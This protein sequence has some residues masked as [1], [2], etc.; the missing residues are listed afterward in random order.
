M[1]KRAA[2]I[3]LFMG[4][5]SFIQRRIR[6]SMQREEPPVMTTGLERIAVKARCEPK[7]RFTSLAHHITKDRVW[8]SLSQIPAK[9]AAGVD[10]PTVT[11]AKE[12]FEE[13][14]ASMLQSVRRQGYRAPEIRRVYI[15]KPGKQENRLSGC[16]LSR[17]GHSDEVPRKCYL[18]FMSRT[19][20]PAPSADV[21]EGVPTKRWQRFMRGLLAGKSSHV[22]GGPQ[23]FLRELKSRMDAPV[24]GAPSWRSAS[25]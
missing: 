1:G 19:F 22:G 3:E 4:N 5:M 13:W 25:D 21:R 17:T 7:L 2:E 9:S 18:P 14:I 11:E 10:G 20:C 24:C 6:P 16:L 12:S 8:E 15:P 23:E